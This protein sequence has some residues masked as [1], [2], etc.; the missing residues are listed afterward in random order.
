MIK[1]QM[2]IDDHVDV[3]RRDARS[4]EILEQL[5]RLMVCLPVRTSREFSPAVTQLF[6]SASILRDHIT[7][8]ITP[9]KA[10]PSSG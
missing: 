4:R 10:P 3:F 2:R 9:K 7:L 5:S 1:M 6:A 8:G